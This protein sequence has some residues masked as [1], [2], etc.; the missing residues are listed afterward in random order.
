M[1][2]LLA[3]VAV[4]ISALAFGCVALFVARRRDAFSEAQRTAWML[5]GLGFTLG[6]ISSVLQ[7]IGAVWG[8][9]GGPDSAAWAEFLRWAPAGNY[10]RTLL[11]VAMACMLAAVPFVRPRF[12]S[13]WWMAAVALYLGAIL[14]GGIAGWSEGSLRHQ[15]HYPNM[16]TLETAEVVTLLSAAFVGL[17]WHSMDR[18]LWVAV[19]IYTFRQVLNVISWSS[20]AWI[21]APGTWAVPTYYIHLYGVIGYGLM[22]LCAWR[23]LYWAKRGVRVPGLLESLDT[24]RSPSIG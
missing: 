18:L 11:R 3:Q 7:N 2:T 12:T 1:L 20:L 16:A 23:R 6:G 14:L 21:D 17:I 10:G 19:L 4:A 13:G 9:V 8:Y 24:A 15:I 5:V 22:L